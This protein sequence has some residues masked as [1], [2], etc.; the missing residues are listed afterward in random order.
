MRIFKNIFSIVCYLLYLITPIMCLYILRNNFLVILSFLV[1]LFL[2]YLK[3]TCFKNLKLHSYFD[4]VIIFVFSLVSSGLNFNIALDVTTGFCLA[5]LIPSVIALLGF[6]L[7]FLI[8]CR[9]PFYFLKKEFLLNSSNE[10]LIAII[11]KHL[12]EMFY[13][14]IIKTR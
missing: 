9:D 3:D 10:K 1:F 2:L 7:F 12:P 6:H 11:C 14:Y 8:K 4:F 5:S 13:N